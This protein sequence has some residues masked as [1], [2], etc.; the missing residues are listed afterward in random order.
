MHSLKRKR[1]NS[2]YV[3]F[4]YIQLICTEGAWESVY[5]KI[6][7][8][9]CQTKICL[10]EFQCKSFIIYFIFVTFVYLIRITHFHTLPVLQ[11]LLN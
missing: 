5:T 9:M 6:A 10:L 8:V 1:G 11:S 3:L 4:R 2:F 7:F